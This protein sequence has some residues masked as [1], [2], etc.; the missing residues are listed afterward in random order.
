MNRETTRC[1]NKHKGVQNN[2]GDVKKKEMQYK[3]GDTNDVTLSFVVVLSLCF[4]LG[5][6][7]YFLFCPIDL[8]VIFPSRWAFLK[9]QIRMVRPWR[10]PSSNP[11]RPLK[12]RSKKEPRLQLFS[13]EL[14]LLSHSQTNKVTR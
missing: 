9:G 2:H 7:R 10:R 12:R 5:V 1:I 14:E 8:C 11:R 6:Y 13:K 4:S 3:C